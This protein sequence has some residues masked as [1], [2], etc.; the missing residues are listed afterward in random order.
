MIIGVII[1]NKNF[2]T[3]YSFTKSEAI[4]LFNFLFD[5]FR[6]FVFSND[7][8]EARVVLANQAAGLIVAIFI[9]ISNCLLQYYNWHVSQNIAKRLTEKRYL[10][11]ERK[12]II[13]NI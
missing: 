8:A 10:T 3:I 2:S 12:E 4:I 7:I 6:H 1:T 13:N 9:S 11:K 5:S